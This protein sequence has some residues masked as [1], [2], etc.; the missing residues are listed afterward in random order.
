MKYFIITILLLISRNILSQ[1]INNELDITQF[2]AGNSVSKNISVSSSAKIDSIYNWYLSTYNIEDKDYAYKEFIYRYNFFLEKLNKS[3]KVFNNDEI[4]SYLNKLKDVILANRNEKNRI[5]VYLV[6]FEQLNAFTNDFGSIYVNIGTIARLENER[7][8]MVILAHEIAHVLS[9]HSFK[10]EDLD[11]HLSQEKFDG[12]N[13]L[14]EADHHK[15][16]RNQELEADS[17]AYIL[18]REVGI[19]FTDLETLFDKLK[20]CENPIY[21]SKIIL[22]DYMEASSIYLPFFENLAHSVGDFLF[23]TDLDISDSLTTHPSVDERIELYNRISKE[24]AVSSSYLSKNNY[25]YYKELASFVLVK[26]LTT[27]RNYLES[28]YLTCQLLQKYPSNE[29]LMIHKLKLLLLIT[30]QKY[31]NRSLSIVNEYGQSC[32]DQN[33][34]H[35]RCQLMRISPLDMNLLTIETIK[36]VQKNNKY[37]YLERLLDFSYQ[38]LYKYNPKLIKNQEN[39][40]L[41]DPDVKNIGKYYY[42]A[43]TLFTVAQQEKSLELR[44]ER[45]FIVDNFFRDSSLLLNFARKFADFENFSSSAKKYRQR[46]DNYESMLTLDQ[47]DIDLSASKA[48]QKCKNGAFTYNNPISD[49]SVVA[50]IQSDT[51]YIDLYPRASA[52]LNYQKTLEVDELI[53]Q[54]LEEENLYQLKLTNNNSSSVSVSENY[55]HSLLSNWINETLYFSD[56][57]YSVADEEL[58]ANSKINN[59]DY[60]VYNL[61]I[62]EN[63]YKSRIDRSIFYDIYFDVTNMGITYV[64]KIAS[65]R[66]PKLEFLR[67]YFYQSFHRNK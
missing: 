48:Y 16:S 8:L 63:N 45:Y 41:I 57:V 18:L 23:E 24:E 46:R 9:R 42:D 35:F 22:K 27:S 51:Y 13:Q 56:L 12:I 29:Y 3:G 52:I 30:Q 47:F 36:T 60:I 19:G 15:F 66:K 49:S 17:L 54:I 5:Q 11:R 6:D 37:P 2:Y 20:H 39:K 43:Y 53:N 33:Y 31:F 21:H 65:K 38:F 67:H 61:N 58:I 62:I 25:D 26:T 4:T 1:K 34:L 7:E 10:M 40:L 64:S 32:T 59:V 50:L 44:Q 14:S 28:L 55:L